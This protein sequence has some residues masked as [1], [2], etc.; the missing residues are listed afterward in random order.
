[1]QHELVGFLASLPD[2]IKFQGDRP[3]AMAQNLLHMPY[4][5]GNSNDF[6]DNFQKDPLFKKHFEL[7]TKGRVVEAGYISLKWLKQQLHPNASTFKELWAILIF[8]IW[9]N[10]YIHCP[11]GS[12]SPKVSVEELLT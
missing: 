8:E 12:Q 6:F 3:A 5:S 10:L 7:L 11:I 4:I 9:F 1:M 2:A